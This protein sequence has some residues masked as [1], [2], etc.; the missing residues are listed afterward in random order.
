ME[1]AAK[2]IFFVVNVGYCYKLCCWIKALMLKK[3]LLKINIFETCYKT[4]FVILIKLLSYQ[5]NQW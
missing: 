3:K 4:K 5:A 2:R 1:K